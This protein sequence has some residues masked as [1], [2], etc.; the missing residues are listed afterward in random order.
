MHGA[1][2]AGRVRGLRA[3][4]LEFNGNPEHVYLAVNFPPMVAIFGLVNSLSGMSSR[5]LRAEFP[6]PAPPLLAGQTAVV[7]SNFA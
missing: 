7:G 1:D 4:L 3:E 5:R 6:R 2:H